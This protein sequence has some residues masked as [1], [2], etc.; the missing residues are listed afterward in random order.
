[1]SPDS[2]LLFRLRLSLPPLP[3]PTQNP[4]PAPMRTRDPR[5]LPSPG[6]RAA[7]LAEITGVRRRRRRSIVVFSGRCAGVRPGPLPWPRRSGS[8]PPHF[9]YSFRYPFLLLFSPSP[10]PQDPGDRVRVRWR[11]LGALR[12]VSVCPVSVHPV[13]VRS[14]FVCSVSA[15]PPPVSVCPVSF[16]LFF[17]RP[18]SSRSAAPAS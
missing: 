5:G 17:V 12:S 10:E 8:L 2:L 13:S 7:G 16:R 9:L 18:P 14:V 11:S 15:P 3:S 1:M 4:A 6:S